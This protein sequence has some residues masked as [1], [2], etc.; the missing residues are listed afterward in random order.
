MTKTLDMNI[1]LR[2]WY[3]GDEES[4]IRLYDSYDRSSCDWELPQPGKCS[5]DQANRAIRRH[6]D[7]AYY[8][9]GYAQAVV[10]DGS[11]V[12]HVEYIRRGDL[13]DASCDL[14]I[15]LLPEA[16]GHGVGSEAVRQMIKHAFEVDN[17][18]C[19]SAAILETNTTARR[20]AEK[21]GMVYRGP[22]ET[23]E[24]SFHGQPCSR[25]VY[26]ICRPQPLP[27]PQGEGVE[28]KPWH[29]RDIDSLLSLFT[30]VD[31]R[32]DDLPDLVEEV[33]RDYLYD[34]SQEPS[35]EWLQERLL[36]RLS[37]YVDQWNALEKAGGSIYRAIVSDGAV[38]GLVFVNVVTGNRSLDGVMGY[39]LLP[40]HCGKGIATK[41]VE[42][43]L[44]EAFRLRG[45][46]RVTAYVY[47]PNVASSRV[48]EKNGFTLEGVQREGVLCQ[49]VPTDYLLYGLLRREFEEWCP[50]G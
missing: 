43:M 1:E 50:L 19:V 31:G 35:P 23:F 4:L 48:L 12:G 5:K 29:R 10:L 32:Y 39:M 22:D 47:K 36:Y 49:G 38:V 30:T 26:E 17:C 45:L 20:M 15:A 42:L 6:V 27:Q 13:H 9:V 21:V 16:C 8:G 40:Q 25:L 34:G 3:F 41:A 24:G 37:Q 28:V 33:R 44:G 14:K 2:Q 18:E 46:H 11:V 7:I